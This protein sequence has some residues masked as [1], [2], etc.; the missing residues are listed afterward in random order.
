M[1][2]VKPP[3]KLC[4]EQLKLKFKK[5][6]MILNWSDFQWKWRCVESELELEEDRE[7]EI[8]ESNKRS[9]DATNVFEKKSQMTE[10]SSMLEIL[11]YFDGC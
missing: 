3:Y 8:A 2:P 1:K 6:W 7:I 5:Q 11:D 9:E 10:L 4:I